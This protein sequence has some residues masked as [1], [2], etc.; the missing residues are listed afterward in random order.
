MLEFIRSAILI[1]LRGRAIQGILLLGF[2]LL[3][4]SYVAA[5]FSPRQPQAVALDVGLSFLRFNL[6]LLA[7]FW[8]QELVGKEFERKTVLLSFA[9]PVAR[10]TY[11]FGRYVGV[12]A[13][14]A[15]AS[16]ILGLFLWWVALV[17]D[18]GYAQGQPVNLGWPFAV[19]VLGIWIDIAVVTAFTLCIAAL[20]TVTMLPLALGGLF[21]IAARSLGPVMDYLRQGADGDKQ[22]V[23]RFGPVLD[24][25]Q[26]VL[27]D[28]SRLDWR[29]WP[30]YQLQ[31]PLD[32]LLWSVAM[33][34]AY[35]GLMLALAV[36]ASRRRELL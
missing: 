10:S 23:E 33:A 31:I 20:S 14:L 25:A 4:F 30:M 9:Y 24:T 17:S 19:A 18:H 28:L 15:L 13:L 36:L 2:C 26:W 27:P 29:A 6:V 34:A 7:I 16:L 3:A 22:M 5:D 1:G 8:V 35:A 21:A 12:L 32:T 11:L